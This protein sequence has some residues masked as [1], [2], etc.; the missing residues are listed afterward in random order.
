MK[1]KREDRFPPAEEEVRK[2]T[3]RELF[4]SYRSWREREEKCP[5]EINERINREKLLPQSPKPA[6]R[7]FWVRNLCYAQTALKRID[8]EM[9]RRG[10]PLTSFLC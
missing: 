1:R 5:N 4:K 9:M 6:I 2:W 10:D 8:L 3:D 7:H